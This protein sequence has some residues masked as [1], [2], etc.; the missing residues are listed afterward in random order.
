MKNQSEN[1]D[2]SRVKSMASGNGVESSWSDV[3]ICFRRFFSAYDS[4]GT[5]VAATTRTSL[6]TV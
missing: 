3:T 1:L 2:V 6:G 5:S 4:K